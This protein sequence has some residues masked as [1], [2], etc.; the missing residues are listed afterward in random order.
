MGS[1]AQTAQSGL[2]GRSTSHG[3]NASS[4]QSSRPEW[5]VQLHN[6]NNLAHTLQLDLRKMAQPILTG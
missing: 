4:E 6:L 5:S 3:L 1:T 2:I